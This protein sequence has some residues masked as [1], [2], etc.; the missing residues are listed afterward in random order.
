MK[1]FKYWFRENEEIVQG[2]I[3]I[4]VGITI[5]TYGMMKEIERYFP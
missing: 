4:L 3:I 5:F 2:V 1:K